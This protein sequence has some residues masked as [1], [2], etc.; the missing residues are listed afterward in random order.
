M[1]SLFRGF[2]NSPAVIRTV[3]LLFIRCLLSLCQV[4]DLLL[5]RGNDVCPKT[6]LFWWNC[7]APIFA[8]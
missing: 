2:N 8:A 1:R 7:F 5:E 3:V 4:E 6:A